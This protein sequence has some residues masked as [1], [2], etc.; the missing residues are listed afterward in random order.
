M[1]ARVTSEFAEAV[2]GNKC[3][4]TLSFS[5]ITMQKI[6]HSA[7]IGD[8]DHEF[9]SPHFLLFHCHFFIFHSVFCFSIAICCIHSPNFLL[10]SL[11][12]VGIWKTEPFFEIE[13]L[14]LLFFSRHIFLQ[15]RKDLEKVWEK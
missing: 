5:V 6:I 10:K 8:F 12:D 3:M 1:R 7:Q 11:A 13:P 9:Q 14:S 2:L 4:I 15:P